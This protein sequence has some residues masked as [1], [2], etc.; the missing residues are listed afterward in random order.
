MPE[1]SCEHV[2]VEYSH[3]SCFVSECFG[4]WTQLEPDLISPACHLEALLIRNCFLPPKVGRQHLDVLKHPLSGL[5][6][7]EGGKT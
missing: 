4:V 7:V 1:P 2:V 3:A 6:L 5:L